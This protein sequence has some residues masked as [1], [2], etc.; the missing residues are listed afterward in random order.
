MQSPKPKKDQV[1]PGWYAILQGKKIDLDDWCHSLTKSFDPIAKELPNGEKV[2][3]S[4]DFDDLH[5][6]EAVRGRALLLIARMNGAMRV[7]NGTEPVSFGGVLRVDEAGKEHRTIFA[8]GLTIEGSRAVLRATAQILAADGQPLPPAPPTPSNPQAW[9]T[10][11]NSYDGL[12]DL[13][14]QLGRADN[15]YDIYKTLEIAA[16]IMGG[17]RGLR[18]L[19]NERVGEYRDLEQTAN[20][21][22]HAR[23]AGL[24]QNPPTLRQAK[25]LLNW[26]VS[27]VFRTRTDTADR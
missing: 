10:L 8:E 9:N 2:M 15:W 20:F 4:R 14:D 5:D 6:A 23:G 16:H 27:E 1:P 7:W 26:I 22:R 25:P 13:L 3:C 19:L 11:A 12:S 17:K 18:L 24:P 21:Y